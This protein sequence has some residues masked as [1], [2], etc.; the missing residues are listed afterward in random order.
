MTADSRHDIV[1]TLRGRVL[2]GVHSGTLQSG[3][4]LPTSR[5]V[6][7]EFGTDYRVAIAAYKELQDEGLIE[8]RPRG[9][10]YVAKRRRGVAGMPPLPEPWIVDVFNAALN[11]EI[12]GPELPDLLARCMET[13]RLRSVVITTTHDQVLGI[14]RELR[15]DFGLESDGMVAADVRDATPTPQAIRRADLL[16]TTEAQADWVRALGETLHKTVIVVA[17]RAELQGGEWAMLLRRPVYVVVA[18]AEFGGMLK[19]FYANVPGVENLNVIVFGQDDLATI[20]EG[21]PTYVTQQVRGHLGESRIPGR[22]IPAARTIASES[23][24]EIFAFVVRQNLE[25][26]AR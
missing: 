6:A 3:D 22:I 9:G 25:A 14:C 12:A 13:L 10:V 19:R 26:L 4:R 8:L 18:T 5:E 16:V 15:D 2:R 24:R 20:P 17:V 21:A 1:D 11:R 23:A 7:A